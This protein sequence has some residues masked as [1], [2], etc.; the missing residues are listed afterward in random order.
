MSS[1]KKTLMNHPDEGLEDRK[2]F[3]LSD[4]LH[5]IE[6]SSWGATIGRHY[7]MGM[8]FETLDM[9]KHE[10][11]WDEFPFVVSANLMP[12]VPGDKEEYYHSA[13]MDPTTQRL[14][15]IE[16]AFRYFG[17]VGATHQLIHS[18]RGS[19][20][21]GKDGYDA[22]VKRF[23]GPDVQATPEVKGW[24]PASR[25]FEFKTEAKAMEFIQHLVDHRIEGLFGLIGF[26]LDQPYNQLGDTGWSLLKEML[27]PEKRPATRVKRAA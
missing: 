13:K 7:P 9:R 16:D 11:G 23:V 27:K 2:L 4:N 18:I 5:W 26:F 20:E 25:S 21:P 24:G 6:S 22:L 12:Q 8:L 15:R 10:T 1:A 19:E 3:K 17:G 14:Q